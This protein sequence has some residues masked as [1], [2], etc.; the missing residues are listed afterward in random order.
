[1]KFSSSSE[2]YSLEQINSGLN[3][4]YASQLG[5]SEVLSNPSLKAPVPSG[6]LPSGE[7]NSE[8]QSA[9]S[10]SGAIRIGQI[11]PGTHGHPNSNVTT[12]NH[13]KSS[14]NNSMNQSPLQTGAKPTP[15]RKV[16]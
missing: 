11:V 4:K 14:G 16:F 12:S 2:K 15:K 8:E 7:P 5:S 9:H 1:M 3:S 6:G 10:N 13:S